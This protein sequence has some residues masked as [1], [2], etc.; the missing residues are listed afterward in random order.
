[1]GARERRTSSFFNAKTNTKT[2]ILSQNE[3]LS[4]EAGFKSNYDGK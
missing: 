3:L 1:L 4:S 2:K